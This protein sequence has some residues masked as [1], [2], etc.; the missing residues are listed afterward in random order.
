MILGGLALEIRPFKIQSLLFGNWRSSC[1]WMVGFDVDQVE[2]T[3]TYPGS[4]A[5]GSFI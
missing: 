3:W 1:R 2:N 4:P 5:T